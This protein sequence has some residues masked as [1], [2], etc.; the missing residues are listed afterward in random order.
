[1]EMENHLEKDDGC[2]DNAEAAFSDDEEELS[3]KGEGAPGI[4]PPGHAEF[5]AGSTIPSKPLAQQPVPLGDP[6]FSPAVEGLIPK[7]SGICS[8]SWP[9][10]GAQSAFPA[11]DPLWS[12]PGGIPVGFLPCQGVFPAL[13]S[14]HRPGTGQRM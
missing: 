4:P 13:G 9:F 12:L 6:S 11:S 3:S 2:Y 1:M 10:P 7:P 5:P 14:A 8:L